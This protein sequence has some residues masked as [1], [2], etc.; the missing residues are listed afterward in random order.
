MSDNIQVIFG[1]S[2]DPFHNGHKKIIEYLLQQ[3]YKHI[4]ILPAFLNPF[5]AYTSFKVAKRLQWI[6]DSICDIHDKRLQVSTFEIDN[7]K[8][9]PTFTTLQY[10]KKQYPCDEFCLVIGEDQLYRLKDW[11][12]FEALKKEVCFIIFGRKG[13]FAYNKDV[14]DEIN[15]K[16]IE[17]NIGISSTQ[18]REG[19]KEHNNAVLEFVAPSVAKDLLAIQ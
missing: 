17:W 11:F 10:F 4:W 15:Y 19:I 5:K 18:I 7:N 12:C 13:Y 3:P 2:F 9:T 1:G 14:F 16:W 8:S 6:Y